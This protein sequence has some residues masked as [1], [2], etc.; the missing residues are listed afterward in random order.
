MNVV[1]LQWYYIKN[2]SS[3]LNLEVIN[4][5]ANDGTPVHVYPQQQA[6]GSNQKWYT[7]GGTST[8]RTVIN[9]SCLDVVSKAY[10]FRIRLL[11]TSSPIAKL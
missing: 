7:D 5:S 8:I 9:D 3:G 10:D 11:F 6:T 4:P 2:R 1:G